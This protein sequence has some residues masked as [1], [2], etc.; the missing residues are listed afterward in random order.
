M[1]RSAHLNL[2]LLALGLVYAAAAWWYLVPYGVVW[3]DWVLLAHSVRGLIDVAAQASRLDQ[4]PFLLPF[5]LAGKPWLWSTTSW[6]CYGS[7]ALLIY[8]AA[9]RVPKISADDAFWMAALSASAPLNQARFALA[10]LPYAFSAFF[11]AGCLYLLVVHLDTR[12][13]F[14]RIAALL[15]LLLATTTS[16]FLALCWIPVL[17][18]IWFAYSDAGALAPRQIIRRLV[19]YAEFLLMPPALFVVHRI[20]FPVSGLYAAYNQF[21]LSPTQALAETAKLLLEQLNQ[22][23]I[24]VPDFATSAEAA[25]AALLLTVAIA[26]F[27]RFAAGPSIHEIGHR[28]RISARVLLALTSTALVVSAIF[29]YVIVGQPPRF[30]GL[31]ET[32]HFLALQMFLGVALVF[33]V[34]AISG[35]R[36]RQWVYFLLLVAFL[37]LDYGTARQY[38]VDRLMQRELLTDF[39]QTRMEPNTLVL[40]LEKQRNL[41]MFGRHFAFYEISNMINRSQGTMDRLVVSNQELID[42]DTGTYAESLSPGVAEKMLDDCAVVARPEYGFGDFHFEG[43]GVVLTATSIVTAV[44]L[45]EAITDTIRGRTDWLRLITSEHSVQSTKCR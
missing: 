3:D 13:V 11:F 1:P 23:T 41:M 2:T 6:L 18:I 29:P 44:S 32:R 4:I 16:S 22:L 21:H 9:R 33:L 43:R 20:F 14:P 25:A 28:S 12:R 15:F 42:P 10:V 40:F 30:S 45:L 35:R 36:P 24:M 17:L 5:Q 38:L 34:R 7:G 26:S 31:W 27:K 39:A 19:H 37:T 8:L